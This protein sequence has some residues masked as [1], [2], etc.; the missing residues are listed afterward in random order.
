MPT[1]NR[2]LRKYIRESLI[3]ELGLSDLGDVLHGSIGLSKGQGGIQKWFAN[4]LKRQLDK[5]GE[6]I[7]GYLGQKL[8]DVLP[9]EVK[10]RLSKHE[11]TSRTSSS[12]SLAKVV[13]TWISETEE[14]LN[15]EFS[16][17]EE[18]QITDFA[19]SEYAEALKK[20]S[21]VSHALFLVKK[22]LDI[23]YGA[24]LSKSTQKIS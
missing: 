13:S 14:L 12:E 23:R 3:S 19:A 10:Q 21:D 7:D 17:V 11:K 8:D 5:T 2:L 20:N 18:K 1:D 6:K 4:F 24:S 9:D 15:K 22:K 16:S